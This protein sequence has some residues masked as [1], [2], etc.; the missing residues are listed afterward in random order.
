MSKYKEG[1]FNKMNCFPLGIYG[2]FLHSYLYGG[3]WKIVL[4]YY[5]FLKISSPSF[6]QLSVLI[7]LSEKLI[8][9][10]SDNLELPSKAEYRSG[11]QNPHLIFSTKGI[12]YGELITRCE[13]VERTKRVHWRDRC[14]YH[15]AEGM[16]WAYQNLHAQGKDFGCADTS[17]RV[18][19][20]CFQ[21]H[22][23]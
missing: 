18:Q 22:W 1:N 15:R 23:K 13:R 5:T 17:K 12:Y 19:W 21:Q 4:P 8:T 11:K 7:N 6:L 3:I 14:H 20:G 9:E 16:A 2:N 10:M